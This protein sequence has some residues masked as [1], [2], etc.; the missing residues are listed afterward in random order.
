[1][2]S[3]SI[4]Q[5]DLSRIRVDHRAQAR[6]DIDLVIVDEYASLMREGV[7]FPPVVVFQN[8]GRSAWC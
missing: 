8:G 4:K 6:A 3:N 7:R 1:M 5:L 2:L